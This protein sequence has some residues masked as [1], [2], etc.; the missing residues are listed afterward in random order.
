MT[1]V[2]EPIVATAVLLL[3]HMPP[4]TAS[5]S[6]VNKVT[7]AIDGPVMADGIALTVIVVV[8]KQVAVN[9]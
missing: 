9:E 1:P 2:S 6:A 5:V 3:V 8:T 4:E 7:Q